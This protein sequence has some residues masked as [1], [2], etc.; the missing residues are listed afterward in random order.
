MKV[1]EVKLSVDTNGLNWELLIGKTYNNGV[2]VVVKRSFFDIFTY[3]YNIP[4][5][6]VKNCKTQIEYNGLINNAKNKILINYIKGD[7]KQKITEL[8]EQIK[9]IKSNLENDPIYKKKN[10][11]NKLGKVLKTIDKL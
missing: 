11:K 8:E 3:Y 2:E 10:R 9:Q 1:L 7:Y 4:Y 5:I 6:K